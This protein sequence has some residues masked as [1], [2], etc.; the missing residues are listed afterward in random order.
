MGYTEA[1]VPSY[2]FGLAVKVLGTLLTV[3]QSLLRNESPELKMVPYCNVLACNLNAR[4]NTH[5][6][7][8]AAS[9]NMARPA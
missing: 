2:N 7:C 5:S 3:R 1:V 4:P 8:Q 9:L 6:I